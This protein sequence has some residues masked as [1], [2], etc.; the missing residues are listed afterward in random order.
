MQ[1]TE[2]AIRHVVP[3]CRHCGSANVMR[4]AWAVWSIDTQSW[5]L[6]ASFDDS[7]CGNCDAETKWFEWLDLPMYRTKLIRDLNDQLRRGEPGPHDRAV[8]TAGVAAMGAAFMEEVAARLRT[9]EAFDVENDPYQEHD[10]GVLAI[11]GETLFFKI[12]YYNLALDRLSDDPADP[13]VTARVL[14]IMLA[15]EY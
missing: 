1:P 14:T 8:M 15:A 2:E 13:S 9:F 10:Y 11:E 7:R 12:D 6:G 5:E 3:V 4:D